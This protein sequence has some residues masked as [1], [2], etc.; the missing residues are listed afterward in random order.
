M[1]IFVEPRCKI[2]RSPNRAEYEKKRLEGATLLNLE[3]LASSKGEDIIQ[4]NFSR[5]FKKH[6]EPIIKMKI[7]SDRVIDIFAKRKIE[8]RKSQLEQLNK[9]LKILN[10]V[11]ETALNSPMDSRAMVALRSLLSEIRLTLD[12]EERHRKSLLGSSEID[13]DILQTKLLDLIQKLNLS[14]EQLQKAK[15]LLSMGGA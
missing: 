14:A 7:E 11:V 12:A 10:E 3:Q 6:F 4:M 1:V 8:E 9:N 5:H 2:C 13:T 15:A